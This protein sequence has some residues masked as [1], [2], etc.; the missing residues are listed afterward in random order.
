M[1]EQWFIAIAAEMEKLKPPVAATKLAELITGYVVEHPQDARRSRCE[2]FSHGL[3][4][5]RN[6]VRC[7]TIERDNFFT[8]TK[9]KEGCENM[10]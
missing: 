10:A 1:I 5:N 2:H 6:G 7:Q 4:E 9:E 3:S 8:L